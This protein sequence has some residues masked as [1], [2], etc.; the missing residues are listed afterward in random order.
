MSY[1]NKNQ[2]TANGGKALAVQQE[3]FTRRD[4]LLATSL[5]K[6]LAQLFE[7]NFELLRDFQKLNY[8][9]FRA[10]MIIIFFLPCSP[11]FPC[12]PGDGIFF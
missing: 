12:F 1:R 5:R 9:I 2:P 11:C 10:K 3:K 6:Q 7:T 8:S 4:T